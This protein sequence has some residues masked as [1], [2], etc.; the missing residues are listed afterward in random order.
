M[1]VRVCS[2][3]GFYEGQSSASRKEKIFHH[4]LWSHALILADTTVRKMA[5]PLALQNFP[6]FCKEAIPQDWF[7]RGEEVKIM[8]RK[9]SLI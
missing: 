6:G 3:E 5:S 7:P 4:D 2:L 8:L 1:Y 9:L